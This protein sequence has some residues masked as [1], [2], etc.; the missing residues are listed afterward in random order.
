M[1][2]TM[3]RTLGWE[4]RP[5]RQV[6]RYS[7]PFNNNGDHVSDT[8]SVLVS[9]WWARQTCPLLSEA[10]FGERNH[11]DIW[12]K[13]SGRGIGKGSEG[14]ECSCVQFNR[15]EARAHGEEAESE[16]IPADGVRKGTGVNPVRSFYAMH[17]DFCFYPKLE[18]FWTEEWC[19]LCSK[20]MTSA[21]L[22]IGFLDK[23]DY[24]VFLFTL[25]ILFL[26]NL[27]SD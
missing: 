14:W 22:G 16:S 1:N 15:K 2:I 13:H 20:V 21:L 26:T 24:V 3:E 23:R 4:S 25:Y 17:K 7:E 12:R 10:T 9:L 5:F 19:G 6:T 18:G 8:A 11:V 27:F